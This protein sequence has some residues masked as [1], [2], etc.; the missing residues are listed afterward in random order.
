[1]INFI[2]FE[3]NITFKRTYYREYITDLW[4]LAQFYSI[5]ISNQ[6]YSFG[7]KLQPEIILWNKMVDL[8]RIICSIVLVE[9]FLPFLEIGLYNQFSFT[10]KCITLS[11]SPLINR[12]AEILPEKIIPLNW[13]EILIYSNQD[14]IFV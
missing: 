6:N 13:P 11:P 12:H 5:L 3:R 14:N 10:R 2:L 4:V 7:I 8:S 9:F 1:V